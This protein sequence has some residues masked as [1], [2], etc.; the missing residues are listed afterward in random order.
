MSRQTEFAHLGI[1]TVNYII[2][3][4]PQTRP[5]PLRATYIHDSSNIFLAQELRRISQRLYAKLPES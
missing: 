2:S 3:F 5:Q 4:F 1:G